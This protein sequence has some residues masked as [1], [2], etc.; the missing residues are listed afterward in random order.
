MLIDTPKMAQN[1]YEPN[2][3][4]Q[5]RI[6]KKLKDLYGKQAVIGPSEANRDTII[7][8]ARSPERR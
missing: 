5:S 2:K 1:P 6:F 4:I 7:A 3:K 8:A